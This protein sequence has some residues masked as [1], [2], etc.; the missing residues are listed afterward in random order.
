MN[1]PTDLESGFSTGNIQENSEEQD[2]KGKRKDGQFPDV[3]T[4]PLFSSDNNRTKKKKKHKHDKAHK[5]T[6][7]HGA[8]QPKE[9]SWKERKAKISLI[10]ATIFTMLFMVGEVVGGY[11][12]G[13]LAI[14]TDA[15]HLL[16]DVAAML[17]SLVAMH[18]SARAP[19]PRLS[20]GWQRT[21]ILGALA[22]VLLIWALVG[23]LVYEAILRLIGDIHHQGEGVDG[24]IMTI[25]GSA[26]LAVNI[27]DAIILAWGNAPHGH[28]HS[29]GGGGGGHAHAHGRL[30]N[31][32]GNVNVR[33]ALIHVVGDCIQ[34]VGVIAAAVLIWVGNE[35]TYGSPKHEGSWYNLAD[36]ITSLLFGA[37]T[38]FI[39]LRLVKQILSVLMET[40]PSH[41]DYK[42]LK[43]RL[44]A[45]PGKKSFI[46]ALNKNKYTYQ[47]TDRIFFIY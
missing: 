18:L 8:H 10:A 45:L 44:E 19:T 4:E 39:T 15:A 13:S 28:A 20:Y 21:E 26:G 6:H 36:P 40:V 41:I 35:L 37:I 1:K 32:E 5:H 25:I 16:T 12:A 9:T 2:K 29:H 17:L 42:E 38:L 33:A 31:G 14:M 27:I 30:L 43:A 3:E 23:I 7:S 22:S 46:E 11:I 47:S 34:S 24:R